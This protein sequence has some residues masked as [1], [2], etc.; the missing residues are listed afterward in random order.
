[1]STVVSQSTGATGNENLPDLR[2]SAAE[3][4]LWE[5]SKAHVADKSGIWLEAVSDYLYRNGGPGDSP[6]GFQIIDRIG[7]RRFKPDGAGFHPV[8]AEDEKP[9]LVFGAAGTG[10]NAI[11][12]YLNGSLECPS[13]LSGGDEINRLPLTGSGTG[14]SAAFAI[15][16]PVASTTEM[17]VAFPDITGGCLLGGGSDDLDVPMLYVDYSTG[18]VCYW[19]RISRGSPSVISANDIR[20]DGWVTGVVTFDHEDTT[21]RLWMD[22]AGA[23]P[24]VEAAFNTDYSDTAAS[25]LPRIG[26]RGTTG[27]PTDL[28]VLATGFLW[29]VNSPVLNDLTART[30]AFAV[31]AE[32][33]AA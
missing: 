29:A 23:T 4:A 9:F 32:K 33:I 6:A 15:R 5:H 14:F 30:A 3:K 20:G 25:R 1:M 21:V 31:A 12:R 18:K 10:E 8:V 7:G 2:W 27:S 22:S 17:G 13:I 11:S 28:A 26:C 24:V 16:V 19:T